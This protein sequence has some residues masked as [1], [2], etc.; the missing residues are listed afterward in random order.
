[1]QRRVFPWIDA[2]GYGA[3]GSP[4]LG[5]WGP[6]D[7][8]WYSYEGSGTWSKFLGPHTVKAGGIYRRIGAGATDFGPTSGQFRFDD[9]FTGG[10]LAASPQGGDAIA[11]LL[12]GLPASGEV[13]T[14]VRTETYINYY[15]GF[16]QDDWRV[17]DAL[18]V[19]L[20]LRFD[21]EDGLREKSNNFTVG[22]DPDAPFPIEVPGMP[23]LRGGLMYAGVD[24]NP[25][26]HGN[27]PS[28]TLG[29][30]AGFAYTFDERTVVRGGSGLFWIPQRYGCCNQARVGTTGYTQITDLFSSADGG[31]TPLPGFELANPFPDGFDQPFGNSRGLATNAGQSLTFVDQNRE[32][33]R[34]WKWSLEVQRELPGDTA[35][36]VGY[37]GSRGSNLAIGGSSN[38]AV[39][40]NQLDPSLASLGSALNDRV[41][42]PFFGIEGMGNLA[43]SPTTTRAQLL[44]PFPQY[45]NI[46]A[47]QV[48]EGRSIYNAM[49]V[50][51]AKRFR[52]NW[53]A[54]VN[55][56]W[57]KMDDNVFGES[58]AFSE[59][60]S[61]ALNAYDLDS[62][63]GPSLLA[64]PHRLNLSVLY[65][66]PSPTGGVAER[67]AGGWS[68]SAVALWHTG[69]P[70]AISQNSNNTGL[71]TALQRPN[72]VSGVDPNTS[73]S[74]EDRL[75]QYLNPAAWEN[76]DPFT[77]GEAPRTTT[78]ARAPAKQNIDLSFE[79]KTH[80][81]GELNLQIRFELINAFNDPNFRGP[82]S[83]V[84]RSDFGKITAVGGFPRTFQ[85]MMRL[86]W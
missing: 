78:T 2:A 44:R 19:N 69:F 22:F 31:L 49:T 16:V 30:R 24:G 47:R 10:P 26:E 21:H 67:I 33:A 61:A 81:S 9:D 40:I 42:N 58:N 84:G 8:Q 70:L 68:V 56:T 27:A 64:T 51:F 36:T 50:N 1:L 57:A 15:G 32:A 71:F 29:P 46:N 45:T 43:I 5:S 54:R 76:A 48:S 79:K 37:L 59:R 11:S 62:E 38:G 75:E 25:T 6:E 13:Q 52:G 82:R 53:G 83:R 23:D 85:Y 20:G 77:L 4:T 41:P 28:I 3:S 65:R 34:L 60:R 39:N 35:L 17:N 55:Y 18:V 86:T 7:R 80:L 72:V 63:W 73:G 74:T 12:L 66:L 14:A